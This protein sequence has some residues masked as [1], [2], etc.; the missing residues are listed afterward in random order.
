MRARPGRLSR[1]ASFAFSGI[2][3]SAGILKPA[4]P[5][6]AIA[7]LDQLLVRRVDSYRLR[8]DGAG[9]AN[10]GSMGAPDVPMVSS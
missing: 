5:R 9:G 2:A 1:A 6:D 4:E 3:I 10:S 7:C 8:L